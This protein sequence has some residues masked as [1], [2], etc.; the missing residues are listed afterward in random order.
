M[1]KRA[2][3]EDGKLIGISDPNISKDTSVYE[4]EF[5]SG[6][7]HEFMANVIAE[8]LVEQCDSEGNQLYL[9]TS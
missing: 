6:E 8:N 2:K 1:V 3:G 7:T 9:I 5:D 4:V